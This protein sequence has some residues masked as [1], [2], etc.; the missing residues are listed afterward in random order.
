VGPRARRHVGCAPARAAVSRGCS[1][2]TRT[3]D[4]DARRTIVYPRDEAGGLSW[5]DTQM[6]HSLGNAGSSEGQ[7]LEIELK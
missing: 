7:V 2:P 5:M 3:E 1:D 4:H 6:T